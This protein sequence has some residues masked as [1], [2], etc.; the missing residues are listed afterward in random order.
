[1]KLTNNQITQVLLKL[2]LKLKLKLA[3][4]FSTKNEN[5]NYQCAPY[6]EARDKDL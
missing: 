4:A 6:D 5:E 1:M 3:K 2:K